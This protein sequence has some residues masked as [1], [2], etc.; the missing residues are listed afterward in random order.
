MAE[1]KVK[2]EENKNSVEEQIKS[3]PTP[4]SEPTKDDKIAALKDQLSKAVETQEYE[5][6]A[7]LRDEIKALGKE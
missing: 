2:A 5:Q 3:D 7:A 6:A 4:T 1:Q